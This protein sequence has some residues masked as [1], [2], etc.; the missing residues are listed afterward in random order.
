LGKPVSRTIIANYVSNIK[1]FYSHLFSEQPILSNH[2]KDLKY[3]K[4]ERKIKVMLEDEL[5]QF[6]RSFDVLQFD[7]Y[8]DWVIARLIFDTGGFNQ[9]TPFD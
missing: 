3:V 9:Y 1:A 4:P 5:K 7:L 6:F 2:L 8:R